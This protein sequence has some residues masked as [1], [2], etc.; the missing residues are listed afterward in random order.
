MADEKTEG[1]WFKNAKSVTESDRVASSSDGAARILTIKDSSESDS[2]T[3]E[4]RAEGAPK[5]AT[6]FSVAANGVTASL[7]AAQVAFVFDGDAAS[8]RSRVGAS[9]SLSGPGDVKVTSNNFI[10]L[11]SNL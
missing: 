5:P 8:F 7:G 3:Y 2:A 4:F 9:F 10:W 11:K 1:K 6:G